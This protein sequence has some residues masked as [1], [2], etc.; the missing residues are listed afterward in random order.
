MHTIPEPAIK[1]LS[2]MYQYLCRLSDEN[3]TQISSKELG[4]YV[5]ISA[6]TIRK[7]ISYLNNANIAGSKYSVDNLIRIIGDRLHFNRER[8]ACIVGI[9]RIGSAVLQYNY[10][11]MNGFIIAAGFDSNI[12]KIETLHAECPLFPSYQIEDKVREL[13]IDLAVL[14]VPAGAA[15]MSAERLIQG[16]IKGIVN[17]TSTTLRCEKHIHVIDIDVTREFRI[18]SAMISL[19]GN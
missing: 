11:K 13:G 3:I 12:N 19:S 17:F 5:D 15:Q 10:F 6:H 9:G 4:S 1:R 18:L 8:K 7:D 16:G 2:I 14:A